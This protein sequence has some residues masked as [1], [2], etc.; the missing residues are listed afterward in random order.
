MEK[1]QPNKGTGCLPSDI[2]NKFAK[3]KLDSKKKKNII[4]H[5]SKCRNCSLKVMARID[6][7]NFF[8]EDTPGEDKVIAFQKEIVSKVKELSKKEQL[9]NPHVDPNP[10]FL[11]T[12]LKNGIAIEKIPLAGPDYSW[13]RELPGPGGFTLTSQ[14]KD[15]GLKLHIDPKSEKRAFLSGTLH[16]PYQ[17]QVRI[18]KIPSNIGGGHI[19]LIVS[20]EE[21]NGKYILSIRTK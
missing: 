20:L 8:N 3:G 6:V 16:A 14:G 9:A 13:S 11:L 21:K 12:L 1:K 18:V 10:S 17:P 5:I 7:Y 15:I 19:E 2:L 4:N